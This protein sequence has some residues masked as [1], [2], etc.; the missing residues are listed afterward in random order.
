M[1]LCNF[2]KPLLDP[3]SKKKPGCE[4]NYG[5]GEDQTRQNPFPIS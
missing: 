5:C 4:K 1:T 3:S 2:K